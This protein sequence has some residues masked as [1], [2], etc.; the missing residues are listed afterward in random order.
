MSLAVALVA[1]ATSGLMMSVIERP[2]FTIQMHPVHKLFGLVMIAAAIV[3]LTLNFRRL[4]NYLRTRSVAIYG[5]ALVAALVLLYGVA[6]NNKIPAE[7][8]EQMD[9]AAARAEQDQ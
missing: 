3:H 8:A 5:G 4:T 2:S 1:M 9:A 7:L 6:I